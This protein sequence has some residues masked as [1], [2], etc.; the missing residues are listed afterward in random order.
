MTQTLGLHRL[1]DLHPVWNL[2][3]RAS[4]APSAC[5][6][7]RLS[8]LMQGERVVGSGVTMTASP[9][10][11]SHSSHSL[12]RA[13]GEPEREG[14]FTLTRE[15][16]DSQAEHRRACVGEVV[17][18]RQARSA[19]PFCGQFVPASSGDGAIPSTPM[20]RYGSRRPRRAAC[21]DRSTIAPRK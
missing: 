8:P 21:A 20:L 6:H 16:A 12:F 19:R 18:S 5:G 11:P 2:I 14:D 10:K 13:H 4:A 15:H 7:G 9:S 17:R 3:E 1:R